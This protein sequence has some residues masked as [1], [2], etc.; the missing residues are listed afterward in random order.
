MNTQSIQLI[1]SLSRSFFTKLFVELLLPASLFFAFGALAFNLLG[2]RLGIPDP[3]ILAVYIF[4]LIISTHALGYKVSQDDFDSNAVLFLESLP[5]GRGVVFIARFIAAYFILLL[6]AAACYLCLSFIMPEE[7]PANSYNY[8]QT[9]GMHHWIIGAFFAIS[10]TTLIASF[11]RMATVIILV[12]YL[13]VTISGAMLNSTFVLLIPSVILIEDTHLVPQTYWILA[14]YGCVFLILSLLLFRLRVTSLI[15]GSSR[16]KPSKPKAPRSKLKILLIIVASVVSLVIAAIAFITYN[17]LKDTT[18][19]STEHAGHSH[20]SS[21]IQQDSNDTLDSQGVKHASSA[22][23]NVLYRSTLENFIIQFPKQHSRS[24]KP[25]LGKLTTIDQ[26]VRQLIGPDIAAETIEVI[27]TNELPSHAAGVMNGN[28]IRIGITGIDTKDKQKRDTLLSTIAHEIAH[29]YIEKLSQSF[30]SARFKHDGKLLHEGCAEWIASKLYPQHDGSLSAFKAFRGSLI[31]SEFDINDTFNNNS[32][33]DHWG[34]EAVYVVGPMFIDAIITSGEHECRIADILNAYVDTY[35]KNTKDTFL[36][37]EI[38]SQLE[39]NIPT[40]EERFYAQLDAFKN[41]NTT[42][43][44]ELTGTP[45]VEY[46]INDG[47]F[48]FRLSKNIPDHLYAYIMIAKNS[49]FMGYEQ[50]ELSNTTTARYRQQGVH[51]NTLVA[52]LFM[53]ETSDLDDSYISSRPYSLLNK[54]NTNWLPLNALGEI[55]PDE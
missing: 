25:V 22:D 46:R 39:R 31:W 55:I 6:I 26:N 20:H 38:L 15:K 43:P 52:R 2:E 9:T 50:L 47:V 33:S 30:A 14:I 4:T 34:M 3:L 29:V 13:T 53:A 12:F 35:Q 49:S 1:F 44:K 41:S 17:V 51:S 42:I 16:S 54:K 37:P 8:H 48:E 5:I 10:L 32:L 19:S 21:P 23:E 7:L 45:P 40:L 27:F 18:N 24:L 11:T 28:T 36:W